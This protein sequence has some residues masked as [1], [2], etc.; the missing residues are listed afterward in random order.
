MLDRGLFALG[1]AGGAV[2]VGDAVT[3]TGANGGAAGGGGS[4]RV[5]QRDRDRADDR[6]GCRG[7]RLDDDHRDVVVT[8]ARVREVDEL[9]GGLRGRVGAGDPQDVAASRRGR[10]RPSEQRTKC[11]PHVCDGLRRQLDLDVV[12]RCQGRA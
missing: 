3:G 6:R 4:Q 7:A 11:P 8:S 12:L 5:N 1:V 2:A 10:S 9:P